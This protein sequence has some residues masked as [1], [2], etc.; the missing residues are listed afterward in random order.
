MQPERIGC[1]KEDIISVLMSRDIPVVNEEPERKG[2][3]RH[4]RK[5]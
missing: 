1:R 2:P 4:W 5:K 3:R